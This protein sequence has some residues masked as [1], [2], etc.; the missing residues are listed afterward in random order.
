MPATASAIDDQAEPTW[1]VNSAP[2]GVGYATPPRSRYS[3][4]AVLMIGIAVVGAILFFTHVI[5]LFWLEIAAAGLFAV[6]WTVQTVEQMP[7][8]SS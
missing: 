7:P 6:F 5:S 1:R 8:R 4:V 2:V 3:L